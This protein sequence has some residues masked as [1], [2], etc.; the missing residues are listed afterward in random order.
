MPKKQQKYLDKI[1]GLIQKAINLAKSKQTQLIIIFLMLIPSLLCIII[2]FLSITIS[3]QITQNL[4]DD[5]AQKLFE[6]QIKSSQILNFGIRFQI[7]FQMQKLIWQINI[8]NEFQGNVIQ[9]Q[10]KKN[11]NHI[12]SILNVDRAYNNSENPQVMEM[13]KKNNLHVSVWQIKFNLIDVNKSINL[14]KNSTKNNI[15]Y[16]LYR[17]IS[18][19]KQIINLE[20][21]FQKVDNSIQNIFFLK[22]KIIFFLINIQNFSVQP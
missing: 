11:S 6:D 22:Q 10:V 17:K 2:T 19:K 7:N 13:F 18:V 20:F 1:V 15:N 12:P 8:L 21:V 14:K 16:F 4:V 9:E 5:F 3:Q